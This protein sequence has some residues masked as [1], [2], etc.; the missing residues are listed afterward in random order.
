MYN[1]AQWRSYQT[2]LLTKKDLYIFN[3]YNLYLEKWK[4]KLIKQHQQ[5]GLKIKKS[6]RTNN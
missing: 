2:N 1:S 5:G 3:S 4:K 6:G